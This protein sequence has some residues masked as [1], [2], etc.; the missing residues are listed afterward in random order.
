MYNQDSI[1][2]E[3]AKSLKSELEKIRDDFKTNLKPTLLKYEYSPL[4]HSLLEK[5]QREIDFFLS[6]HRL[7][8]SVYVSVLNQN[9]FITGRTLIDE[10]VW[11]QIQL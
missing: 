11:E 8:I 9:L 2:E 10:I 4:T 1:I 6:N 5:I 7:R 3:R